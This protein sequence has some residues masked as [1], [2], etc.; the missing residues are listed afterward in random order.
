MT[1]LR[2]NKKK[3]NKKVVT[4][5]V[6]L[7]LLFFFG[8]FIQRL[9]HLPATPIVAV[10]NIIIY[11]FKTSIDYFKFKKT[12]TNENEELRKENRRLE[13]ENLTIESLKRENES[14]K[15]IVEYVDTIEDFDIAKVLNQPPYSPYDT[16]LV[17]IDNGVSV[18]SEVY[19][20]G[21]LL[22]EVEEVYN[23][24]AV[25]RLYSS[26]NK[27]IFV[28]IAGQQTEAVGIGGGGFVASLP[29]DLD[30]E[31]NKV[32]FVNEKP[33]GKIDAIETDESGAFQNIYFRYPFN[34][35]SIDFVEILRNN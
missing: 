14:L 24:T 33:I 9:V 29:K 31:N 21:V 20:L 6:V 27:N 5:I 25:V 11:P 32:V 16:F 26:P 4:I 22:G 28:Q 1:Y 15:N 23:N 13:I 17:D 35:N 3:T 18:G 10:K 2:R 30:L 12:L 7:L 8:S 19:F 34:V